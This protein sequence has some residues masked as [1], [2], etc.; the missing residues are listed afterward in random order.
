[1]DLSRMSSDDTGLI[2]RAWL[3]SFPLNATSPKGK[4]L[5][6]AYSTQGLSV[7]GLR[8]LINATD[9]TYTI[10]ETKDSTE[11]EW[12]SGKVSFTCETPYRVS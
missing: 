11:G 9:V 8:V 2:R 1:M 5:H 6:F 12:L 7:G 3:P 4:C 10:W